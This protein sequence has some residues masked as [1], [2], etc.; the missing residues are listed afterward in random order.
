MARASI[1]IAAATLALGAAVLAALPREAGA[2]TPPR[3]DNRWATSWD[4]ALAEAKERNVPIFVTF[5]QDG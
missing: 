4:G 3:A 5:H 2:G 1:T